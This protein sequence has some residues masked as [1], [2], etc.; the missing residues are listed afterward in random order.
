MST[1]AIVTIVLVAGSIAGSFVLFRSQGMRDARKRR[2]E[3]HAQ[4]R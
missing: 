3:K 1:Y 4:R 2:K